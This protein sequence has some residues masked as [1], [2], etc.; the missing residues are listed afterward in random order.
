MS[1]CATVPVRKPLPEEFSKTAQIPDIPRAKFWG[2]EAPSFFEA[3]IGQPR[4]KLKQAFSGI[5]GKAHN[6]LALSGGGANGAFGAGLMVGWSA[7]GTRPEFTM[8]TGISTGALM[9]PFVFL[10]A[11]YDDLLKEMY[12]THST[13]DLVIK[14]NILTAL[15]GS[16]FA[17]TTP[18]K[19]MLAKY[20]D[21]PVMAAIATEYKKGRRLWVGTSNL[22]AKRP[23]IWNIGLIAASGHPDALKLIHKII[24]ASASIPGA[25]PPVLFEVETD[26]RRYDELHVDGGATEQVFLYPPRLDW[27][28]IIQKL[29]VKGS[30]R[31]YVVRNS[32]LKPDYEVVKPKIL[33]ISGN[34]ID[35]LIRTQGI[36]DM[37]R[38]YVDCQRDGIDYNLAYIPKDFDLK[39]NE[40]FDPVYMGKLFEMGYQ[41]A[42][43]GY[44]WDK[45]PPGF[46]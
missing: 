13:K 21:Q 44:P 35:S 19:K 46:E 23:V 45:G 11:A 15:T 14:Y 38:I 34:T 30:P 10:G 32:F 6:Y 1:N 31:V 33:P 41:M 17:D 24:L 27:K 18:L 16:S 36:G 42:K 8:V 4:E 29:E 3:V 20:I 5:Y 9:A 12:T 28:V 25:F 26:G 43:N 2:D 7:A 37:Y 22:D 40:D 39:P